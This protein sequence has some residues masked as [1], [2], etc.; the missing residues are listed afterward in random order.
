MTDAG[1]VN[2]C[3][4]FANHLEEIALAASPINIVEE[5][6]SE[7]G[8]ARKPEQDND[9]DGM[10]HVAPNPV[11]SRSHSQYRRVPEVLF[12]GMKFPKY[13]E[14]SMTMQPPLR[15]PDG[16]YANPLAQGPSALGHRA[17]LMN[18]PWPSRKDDVK[19]KEMVDIHGSKTVR[20][21]RAEGLKGFWEPI[22]SKL[23]KK[24]QQ[25]AEKI[26]AEGFFETS[27]EVVVIQAADGSAAPP[28]PPEIGVFGKRNDPSS[29]L[30]VPSF[31]E[32]GFDRASIVPVAAPSPTAHA[33][34]PQASEREPNLHVE[35]S[36]SF[37]SREKTEGEVV[38]QHDE[39]SLVDESQELL[40]ETEKEP[41]KSVS[42]AEVG[43]SDIKIP[44]SF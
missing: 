20:P 44:D 6:K 33:Q 24:H 19:Q 21:S 18:G 37:P 7:E 35:R 11:D 3:K 36:C 16:P 17:G 38:P 13:V 2:I 41:V 30:A 10:T 12:D 25:R 32:L 39:S 4:H 27:R 29:L 23:K 14:R 40:P 43:D 5:D 15:L 34:A 22:G 31:E 9:W 28:Q 42:F 1:P 26:L 8:S